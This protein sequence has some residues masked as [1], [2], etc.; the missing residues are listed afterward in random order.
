MLAI[1]SIAG[2]ALAHVFYY[3]AMARIGVSV[4]AG[5]V[6]LQPFLTGAG[7]WMWFDEQ[8]TI[9]QWSCGAVAIVGA[10]F[11]LYAQRQASRGV[12]APSQDDR[13]VPA[14]TAT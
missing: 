1:S 3:A 12:V 4:A 5:V 6:L 9:G 11:M 2:I 13:A 7:S 14:A 8:L 10:G